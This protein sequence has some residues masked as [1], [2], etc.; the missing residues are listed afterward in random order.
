MRK[1]ILLLV[2]VWGSSHCLWSADQYS[3][4][5]TL[6]VWAKNGLNLREKPDTKSKIL[7][8]VSFGDF[9]IIVQPTDQ[10]YHVLGI[11]PDNVPN[12]YVQ[13]SDPVIFKG[14]WVQVMDQFGQIGF[15]IDQYLL[16]HKP[17]PERNSTFV[18]FDILRTDTTFLNPVPE[19]G[20][21]LNLSKITYLAH[22]ITLN[23]EWG[24]VWILET[25][26]LPDHTI[27]EALVRIS[28]TLDNFTNW[29]VKRNWKEEIIIVDD[30]IC[31]MRIWMDHGLVRMEY[32][33]SC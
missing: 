15:V 6:F 17:S 11:K 30:G 1:W 2:L 12:S 26:Q 7:A 18:Q 20:G 25:Y 5:D 29:R 31:G 23:S 9:L 4:G 33:C 21:A 22:G 27:Q 8:K 28:S 19:D 14:K 16:R 32:S 13:E 3:K 24:G 10:E